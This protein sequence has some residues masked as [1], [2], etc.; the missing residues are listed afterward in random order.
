MS[1]EFDTKV[2]P[3]DSFEGMFLCMEWIKGTDEDAGIEFDL[4]TGAGLGSPL[5]RLTVTR[6]DQRRVELI[7]IRKG[8]TAW[9]NRIVSEMDGETP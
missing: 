6:G 5:M 3:R 4:V 8:L 7:D 2:I 1:V 9:V